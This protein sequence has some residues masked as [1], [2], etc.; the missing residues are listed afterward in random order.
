MLTQKAEAHNYSWAGPPKKV[1]G[2][3][4]DHDDLVAFCQVTSGIGKQNIKAFGGWL[5]VL[6]W[7]WL[8]AAATNVI[9]TYLSR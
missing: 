5:L 7:L 3:R 9:Y 4:R 1:K 6:T 2:D 8:I